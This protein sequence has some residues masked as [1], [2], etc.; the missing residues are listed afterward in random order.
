ML[1]LFTAERE[2][3]RHIIQCCE[4]EAFEEGLLVPLNKTTE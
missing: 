3:I 2:L 4:K 1:R